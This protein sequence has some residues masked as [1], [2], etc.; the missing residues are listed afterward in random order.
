MKGI[1]TSF[2]LFVIVTVNA[3]QD[4]QFTHFMFDRLSVNPAYAGTEGDICITAILRQQWSGFTG[5]PKTGLLNVHGPI[6]SI[7]SG[8]GL[9]LY[10]D[11]LGQ[12]KSTIARLAYAYHIPVN[13]GIGKF[14]IGVNLG[15]VNRSL[16]SDWVATDGF[17]DDAAIPNSGASSTAFDLGTGLYYTSPK[18][19]VGIS[20]T[21]LPESELPDVNI[22]NARHYYVMGGYN[23]A[24]GG[25]D[26]FM[27]K[28]QIFVKSDGSSTQVDINATFLLNNM[29]WAGVSYRT[30]D[31]IAPMIGYQHAFTQSMLKIGYSYDVTTSELSNHSSGSHEIML[32]YCFQIIKKPDVQIYHNP[33]WL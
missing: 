33:R 30:E 2:L 24:I 14:S 10:L 27:L 19:W 15:M 25:D 12:E 3:Q 32:N 16:G 20:S 8:V 13:G 1:L 7:N 4:P 17:E 29:V 21:H 28:P 18:V 11:E 6:N 31:A 5:A 23:W 26:N 22:K 9:S